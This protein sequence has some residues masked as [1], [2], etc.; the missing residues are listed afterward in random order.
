MPWEMGRAK[1]GEEAGAQDCGWEAVT[2]ARR[3]CIS[4]FL[5]V[6]CNRRMP[7]QFRVV[8]CMKARTIV[9]V[10]VFLTVVASACFVAMI[11][12]SIGYD[13]PEWA[14]YFS[15]ASLACGPI[16]WLWTCFSLRSLCQAPAG[17][18][19]DRRRSD[20]LDVLESIAERVIHRRREATKGAS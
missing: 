12:A 4:V 11:V 15:L 7:C 20:S 1:D 5:V 19:D 18:T 6:T 13:D 3:L 14:L 8:S 10:S 2:L 16:Q 17:M 9:L